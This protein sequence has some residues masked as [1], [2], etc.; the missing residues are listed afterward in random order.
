MLI[1]RVAGWWIGWKK[2]IVINMFTTAIL[3]SIWK[4]RNSIIFQ[5]VVWLDANMAL[6]KA[7]NVLRRWKGLCRTVE[8]GCVQLLEVIVESLDAKIIELHSELTESRPGDHSLSSCANIPGRE[9]SY[10]C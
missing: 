9:C 7:L 4:L 3:W 1:L 8:A 2:H 6:C 5:G 10:G